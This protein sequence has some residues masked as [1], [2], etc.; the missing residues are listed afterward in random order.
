MHQSNEWH[1]ATPHAA[2]DTG[3]GG[4]ATTLIIDRLAVAAHS[5]AL[6][7]T[8][9]ARIHLDRASAAYYR[10]EATAHQLNPYLSVQKRMR[11]ANR[12]AARAIAATDRATLAELQLRMLVSLDAAAPAATPSCEPMAVIVVTV[13]RDRIEQHARLVM[14]TAASASRRW[15]RVGGSSW[16]CSDADWAEHEEALG[17]EL[18]EFCEAMD[19]PSRVADMLPRP[20]AP[21]SRAAAIAAAE[22]GHG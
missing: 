19:L 12:A 9:R 10:A 3:A 13:H 20:P 16:R 1:Q 2:A 6:R 11:L 17:V 4:E 15:T 7:A 21:A 14:G 8:M 5:S 22:V 18:T